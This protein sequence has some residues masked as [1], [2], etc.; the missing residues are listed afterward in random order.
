MDEFK[1]VLFDYHA[2]LYLI[3]AVIH[4]NLLVQADIISQYYINHFSCFWQCF[5]CGG[6]PAAERK[7]KTIYAKLFLAIGKT[8]CYYI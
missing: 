8:V 6:D 2:E 7:E 1:P 5:L 3:S 4:K